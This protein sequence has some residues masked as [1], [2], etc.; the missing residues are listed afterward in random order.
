MRD[1]PL[2]GTVDVQS[3]FPDMMRDGVLSKVGKGTWLLYTETHR[4]SGHWLRAWW[5]EYYCAH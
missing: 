3:Q 1:E 4:S 5:G 2:L